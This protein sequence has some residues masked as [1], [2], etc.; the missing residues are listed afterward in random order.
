MTDFD[1]VTRC[2]REERHRDALSLLIGDDGWIRRRFRTDM[3]HAWYLAGTEA[4]DL[5]DID[6][7]LSCFRNS[8]KAWLEDTQALM[9]IA[10]CHSD[11]CQPHWSVRYLTRALAIDRKNPDLIYKLGNAYY[12]MGRYAEA[13]KQYRKA[14]KFGAGEIREFAVRNLEHA[15]IRMRS[16]KRKRAEVVETH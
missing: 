6:R 7:A 15:L 3:N 10:N 12:D 11:R 2:I 4:Y 9:A 13:A 16:G 14:V 5:G 8:V 1:E